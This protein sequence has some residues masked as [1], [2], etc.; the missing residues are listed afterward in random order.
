MLDL[1]CGCGVPV[2]RDL[3]AAGH[4]VFGVDISEVQISRAWRLVPDVT[5]RV[6]DLA[7]ADFPDTSFDAAVFLYAIIHQSLEE[8]PQLLKRISRWLRPGGQLVLTAGLQAWT[9]SEDG[10]LGTRATMWWCQADAA[11]YRAWLLAAGF[12]IDAESEIPDGASAH[13]LF[14]A[15]TLSSSEHT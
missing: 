1:G 2:A 14:W 8:Q 7:T 15:H 3:S 10:W 6:Q 5:F 9:G 12:A 11:S 13:A 4:T